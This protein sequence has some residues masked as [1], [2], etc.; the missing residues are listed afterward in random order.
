MEKTYV[1]ALSKV[2]SV[3]WC[4]PLPV[5]GLTTPPGWFGMYI[6]ILSWE[7]YTDLPPRIIA[8]RLRQA[9]T[10]SLTELFLAV[11]PL[12]GH[13]PTCN[14]RTPLP[15]LFLPGTNCRVLQGGIR[16]AIGPIQACWYSILCWNLI[17]TY[18]QCP[19]LRPL[20]LQ[21]FSLTFNYQN[22]EV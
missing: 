22:N 10:K 14:I 19:H 12:R 15:R 8:A 17:T 4:T 18:H 7:P 5:W 1:S 6:Y 13:P 9:C 3:K 21:I 11:T 20:P 2:N 16:H